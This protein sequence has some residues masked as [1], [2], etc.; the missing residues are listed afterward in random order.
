[1]SRA[2]TFDSVLTSTKT[3]RGIGSVIRMLPAAAVLL[4][5]CG[6]VATTMLDGNADVTAAPR[7]APAPN[8]MP[9][10]AAAG[11]TTVPDASAVFSGREVEIEE[12]APTF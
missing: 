6:L 7:L 3:S 12:P 1:M 5:A 8:A 2:S 9:T 4:G 10:V 11:S